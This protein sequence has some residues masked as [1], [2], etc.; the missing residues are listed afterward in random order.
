MMITRD[1]QYVNGAAKRT[2]RQGRTLN[3]IPYT[4]LREA[5]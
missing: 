4:L 1:E 2:K 3:P 5:P